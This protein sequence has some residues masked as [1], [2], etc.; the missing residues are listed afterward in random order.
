EGTRITYHFTDHSVIH[1]FQHEYPI[2]DGDSYPLTLPH[3]IQPKHG[4]KIAVTNVGDILQAHYIIDNYLKQKYGTGTTDDLVVCTSHLEFEDTVYCVIISMLN[5]TACFLTDPFEVFSNMDL[6]SSPG[7][8]AYLYNLN[9]R[10]FP[11]PSFANCPIITTQE[12]PFVCSQLDSLWTSMDGI[13]QMVHK[14]ILD[15][16]DFVKQL[17][18]AQASFTDT[19][20]SVFAIMT[21]NTQLTLAQSKC[22]NLTSSLSTA[23]LLCIMAT[24][25]N[26][27]AAVTEQVVDLQQQLGASTENVA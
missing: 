23:N 17:S 26:A 16:Q 20:A 18:D 1:T 8:P 4:L 3:Y 7:K 6:P 14:L 22:N 25:D 2:V 11:P 10:G 12:S 5:I 24:D 13:S 15:H 27:Q 9:S 21:V 19:I